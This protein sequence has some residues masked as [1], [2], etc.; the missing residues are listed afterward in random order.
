[1]HSHR[2]SKLYLGISQNPGLKPVL[3]ESKFQ[4]G[5]IEKP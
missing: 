3:K 1:M 2:V 4:G 5:V